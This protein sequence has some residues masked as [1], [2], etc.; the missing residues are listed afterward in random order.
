MEKRV[1]KLIIQN[2]SL[3]KERQQSRMKIIE[4]EKINN[5]L[6]ATLTHRV[7]HSSGNKRKDGQNSPK[8]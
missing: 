7:S 1:L 3:V 2:E 4:L 5:L 8:V 6:D